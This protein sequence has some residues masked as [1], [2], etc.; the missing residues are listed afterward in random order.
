MDCDDD[1]LCTKGAYES[2]IQKLNSV[3][4]KLANRA[5]STEKLARCRVSDPSPPLTVRTTPD[6][7]SVGSLSNDTVVTVLDY[8]PNKS[9]IFVGKEDRSPIG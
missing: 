2:R 6:G 5:Q 3:A 7:T 4:A 8:S 9:W 1:F